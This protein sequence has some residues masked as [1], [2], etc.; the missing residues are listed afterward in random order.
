AG[1]PRGRHPPRGPGR[2]GRHDPRRDV[3]AHGRA[4]AASR[5]TALRDGGAPERGVLL[6]GRRLRIPG[7]ARVQPVLRNARHEAAPPRRAPRMT[8]DGTFMERKKT[9][10]LEALCAARALLADPTRWTRS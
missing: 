1:A 10:A 4:A 3:A 7:Q 8:L 5:T 2:R 9:T 6:A